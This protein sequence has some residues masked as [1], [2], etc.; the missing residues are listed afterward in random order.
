MALTTN[1][2]SAAVFSADSIL[3]RVAVLRERFSKY[4]EFRK[5]LRE[6]GALNHRELRDL[7]LTHSAI[8]ST[9]FEAVYG[10]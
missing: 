2:S 5:T 6:L 4:M 3:N 1:Y 10:K 9:A 8:R 7:G